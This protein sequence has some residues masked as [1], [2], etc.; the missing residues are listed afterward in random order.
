M[1]S[2]I[3]EAQS[4]LGHD[5]FATS[6][7]KDPLPRGS[8]NG[9]TTCTLPSR[10]P[11]WIHESNRYPAPLRLVNKAATVFNLR[12]A[13]QFGTL[14]DELRPDIVHSHSMVELPPAI[15]EKAARRGIAVVHT[16][17]DYDLLC[18]RAALFKDGQKCEPRHLACRLLSAPKQRMH[19]RISAVAAVSETVLDTHIEYGLFEHLPAGLRTV[20]WNPCGVAESAQT[21]TNRAPGAP[22]RFGYLGRLTGEKGVFEIIAACKR[23]P[24]GSWTLDIA[25]EGPARAE[26][27]ELTKACRLFFMA[28]SPPARFWP[29]STP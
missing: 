29:R 28:M 9:V 15:W 6:L 1:A 14:L 24:T 8:Y 2:Q 18:I 27:E 19:D 26:L 3:A 10:N 12:T 5:V 7:T 21:R 13:A 4:A 11:L 25:G 20:I 22:Y 17:H 23:L 16:M